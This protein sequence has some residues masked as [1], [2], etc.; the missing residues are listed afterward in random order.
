MTVSALTFGR[1]VRANPGC[2]SLMART[3][4]EDPRWERGAMRGCPV[5]GQQSGASMVANCECA[6]RRGNQHV[7]SHMGPRTEGGAPVAVYT[8]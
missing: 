2:V 7:V 3:T 5:Q 1:P 6:Y 8:G 4:V